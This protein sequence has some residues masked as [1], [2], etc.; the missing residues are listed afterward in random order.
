[1]LLTT[2][3]NTY[4]HSSPLERRGNNGLRPLVWGHDLVVVQA[5]PEE[6]D[7][8]GRDSRW[9]G[10]LEGDEILGDEG[11]WLT[12]VDGAGHQLHAL[13]SAYGTGQGMRA[14]RR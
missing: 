12:R 13:R 3:F 2:L 1:M 7:D 4:Q 10:W 8:G 11:G 14:R 9:Q 6:V 5:R